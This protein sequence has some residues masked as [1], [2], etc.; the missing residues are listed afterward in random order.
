MRRTV[1]GFMGLWRNNGIKIRLNWTK[2]SKQLCLM[3]TKR[4]LSL[5]ISQIDG[6]IKNLVV[7]KYRHFSDR[8]STV[9]LYH[10][11]PKYSDM[12]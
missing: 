12:P 2:I 10:I 7:S 3:F 5:R 8:V 9:H 1:R 11:Y 6:M 4:K